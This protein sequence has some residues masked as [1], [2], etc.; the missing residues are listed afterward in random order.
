MREATEFTEEGGT[1]LSTFVWNLFGLALVVPLVR[2]F[3]ARAFLFAVLALT[4]VRMVPVAISMIGTGLRRDTVLLMG[5]L[6]PRGLA[7]VVFL[8]ISV[9]A[10]GESHKEVDKAGG[11]G[12]VDHHVECVLARHDGGSVG[13]V[14][15]GRLETAPPDAPELL[16]GPEL[17]HATLLESIV[18]SECT[19]SITW[20]ITPARVIDPRC[21]RIDGQIWL[22]VEVMLVRPSMVG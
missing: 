16:P 21:R 20:S 2:S 7:S 22:S 6:G 17:P 8:L 1:L 18:H 5:W 15:R 3:D 4:V 14:V 11:D 9:E 13:S 10:L 19:L 12:R